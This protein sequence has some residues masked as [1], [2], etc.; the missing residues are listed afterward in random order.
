MPIG[1][2]KKEETVRKILVALFASFLA[3][4]LAACGGQTQQPAETPEAP[5]GTEVAPG[6]FQSDLPQGGYKLVCEEPVSGTVNVTITLEEGQSLVVFGQ[7]EQGEGEVPQSHD[8]E[9][10]MTDY[11]YEGNSISSMDYDPGDYD[12][13]FNLTDAQGTVYVFPYATGEIDFENM[14]ADEIATVLLEYL[15]E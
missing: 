3:V 13:E 4:V 1:C 5:A 8:G 14:D 7:L 6:I 10:M 12:V 9:W 11:L 2:Q 15:G